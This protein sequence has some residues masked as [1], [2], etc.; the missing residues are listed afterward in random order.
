MRSAHMNKNAFY[1]PDISYG[2]HG[3]GYLRKVFSSLRMTLRSGNFIYKRLEGVSRVWY[4][5][6]SWPRVTFE[7]RYALVIPEVPGF[8]SPKKISKYCGIE[9]LINSFSEKYSLLSGYLSER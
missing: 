4:A 1:P 7:R 6:H 2:P 5:D 8:C 3:C 9:K